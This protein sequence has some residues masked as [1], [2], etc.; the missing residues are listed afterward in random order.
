MPERFKNF[1][2]GHLSAIVKTMNKLFLGII[3]LII[4]AVI[5]GSAIQWYCSP[6]GTFLKALIAF[7]IPYL[8]WEIGV[9]SYAKWKGLI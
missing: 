1:T 5:L 4:S 6:N 7:I 8:I 3:D 2:P 9:F